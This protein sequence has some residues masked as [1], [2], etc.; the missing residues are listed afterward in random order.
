MTER[1]HLNFEPTEG[2]LVPFF[3]VFPGTAQEETRTLRLLDGQFGLSDDEFSF[4]ETYCAGP[5]CDCRRVTFHVMTQDGDCAATI[6]YAFDPPDP[7]DPLATPDL[8]MDTQVYLQPLARQGPQAEELLQLVEE[9]LVADP[10]YVAR[11]ERHYRMMKAAAQEA[12]RT[13]PVRRRRDLPV[14]SRLAQGG[15]LAAAG[16]GSGKKV[17]RNAPCPCG[18][19]SKFKKCCR[20][21]EA[22]ETKILRDRGARELLRLRV[23]SLRDPACS[24]TF[25]LRGDGTLHDLHGLIQHEFDLDDDHLYSFFMSGRYWDKSTEVAGSPYGGVDMANSRGVPAAEEKFLTSLDLTAGQRFAYLFDYGDE[26]RH[27]IDVLAIE[28]ATPEHEYPRVIGREGSPPPQ[29]E[30]GYV[31]EDE[32]EV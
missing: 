24:R 12:Q 20:S 17:G 28:E 9:L 27:D 23:R 5:D 10:E 13:V 30:Y 1:P 7:D 3:R 25:E 16:R 21:L 22:A 29:Y 19:G 6:G 18:S 14:A 8:D 11:L 31:F 32:D 4:V 2:L 26:L 15:R